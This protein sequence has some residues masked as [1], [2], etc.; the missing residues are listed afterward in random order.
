M[1]VARRKRLWVA[2]F[3]RLQQPTTWRIT[4]YRQK[5]KTSSSVGTEWYEQ[6]QLRTSSGFSKA[7]KS[8]VGCRWSFN[9][10]S[11][12][13]RFEIP[14]FAQESC[15][16]RVGRAMDKRQSEPSVIEPIDVRRFAHLGSPRK[17]YTNQAAQ[18][19]RTCA[20]IWLR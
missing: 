4:S 12:C 3:V 2:E 9:H 15:A 1:Q 5:L 18:V 14:E 7:S 11:A 16:V 19:P 6:M 17:L 10:S 20:A 8:A 13:Q